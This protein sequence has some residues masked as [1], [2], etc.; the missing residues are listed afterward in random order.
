MQQ[1]YQAKSYLCKDEQ[2]N[3]FPENMKRV[4]LLFLTF[5]LLDFPVTWACDVCGCG[6]SGG[7]LGILPQFRNNFAGMRWQYLSFRSVSH[8]DGTV[9]HEHFQDYSLWARWY[10]HKR[11]Q[12]LAT[13]PVRNTYRY[14]SDKH[15]RVIGVGDANILANYV[16]INTG[17]SLFHTWKQT[18]LVGS[19]VKMPTGYFNNEKNTATG[20]WKVPPSMQLGTSTWDYLFQINYTLRRSKWGVNTNLLYHYNTT[21]AFDYRFGNQ[22]NGQI[23]FFYW[24]KKGQFSI[25]PQIGI[26]YTRAEKDLK[27]GR[28]EDLTGGWILRSSVGFDAYYKRVSLGIHTQSPLLHH[29]SGGWSTPKMGASMQFTCLF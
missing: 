5:F 19:G 6:V 8:H 9:S 3:L 18:L 26:W 13:L 4:T 24:F 1:L 20:L 23:A 15:E 28:E 2:F 10:P 25:L 12:L 21:N 17:D 11:W 22:V 14:Y 16:A 27:Y 7:Y 29:I